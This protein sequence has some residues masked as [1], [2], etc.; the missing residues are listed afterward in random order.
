MRLLTVGRARHP[1][2]TWPDRDKALGRSS[3]AVSRTIY[4]CLR[5]LRERPHRRRLRVAVSPHNP[6]YPS[7]CARLADHFRDQLRP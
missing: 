3:E 2:F 6:G 1:F 5:E 7:L 4:P